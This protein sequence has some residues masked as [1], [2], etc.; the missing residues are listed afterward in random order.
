[1]DHE[2]LVRL[3]RGPVSSPSPSQ[4]IP[5]APV[6]KEEAA[7]LVNLSLL[8]L[9]VDSRR[10]VDKDTFHT[11]QTN[12]ALRELVMRDWVDLEGLYR[13][14]A[15]ILGRHSSD[16][17]SFYGNFR[18][19]NAMFLGVLRKKYSQSMLDQ[20]GILN[21]SK[22]EVLK[23][24][25]VMDEFHQRSGGKQGKRNLAVVVTRSKRDS[26]KTVKHCWTISQTRE[27]V[28][29]ENPRHTK[30]RSREA[31]RRVC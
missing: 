8:F 9:M 18:M 19:T 10:V 2:S 3:A 1:M 14:L 30:E 22:A 25:R 29:R 13:V 28:E 26:S 20:I 21:K 11:I 15:N 6:S 27:S 12:A 4:S 16:K 7:R 23:E 24:L 17:D 31:R 5:D